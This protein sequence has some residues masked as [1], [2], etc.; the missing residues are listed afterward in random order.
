MHYF[1]KQ[2]LCILYVVQMNFNYNLCVLHW[3][4]KRLGVY[5]CLNY[6]SRFTPK[7]PKKTQS[8][9]NPSAY[10]KGKH[11]VF[12]YKSVLNLSLVWHTKV[13]HFLGLSNTVFS[14]D[15]DTFHSGLRESR[16]KHSAHEKAIAHRNMAKNS[17]PRWRDH[18]FRPQSNIYI[19]ADDHG[20]GK[21]CVL[22]IQNM[23]FSTHLH[24]IPPCTLTWKCF[25]NQ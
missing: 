6:S 12:S 24:S 10:L 15:W 4:N 20:L 23:S 22:C 13:A 8:D 19:H 17:I 16:S 11:I 21:W 7:G 2:Q 1:T 18:V 9:I 14:R 5:F 25:W 3:I